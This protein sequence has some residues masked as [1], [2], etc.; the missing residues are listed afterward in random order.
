MLILH[1][2]RGEC[3]HPINERQLLHNVDSSI[4]IKERCSWRLDVREF[5]QI[6]VGISETVFSASEHAGVDKLVPTNL[7]LREDIIQVHPF[8]LVMEEVD[9]DDDLLNAVEQESWRAEDSAHDALI[10]EVRELRRGKV[11][12]LEHL[13]APVPQVVQDEENKVAIDAGGHSEALLSLTPLPFSEVRP[14]SLHALVHAVDEHGVLWARS[15]SLEYKDR[16]DVVPSKS[17]QLLIHNSKDPRGH[18]P[19]GI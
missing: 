19:K 11:W 13:A 12:R 16:R 17:I 18:T 9:A 14:A 2:L 5:A 4:E 7:P 8:K 15:H 3:L 1:L 10:A 6:E